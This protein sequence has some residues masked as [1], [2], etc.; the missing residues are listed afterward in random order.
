MK[1]PMK[2]NL[3][4]IQRMERLLNVASDETRLKI[5]FSLIDE[6]KCSCGIEHCCCG[7]C[8]KRGCMIEKCV[9]EIVE[10][11]KESQSLVS[12]QLKVLKDADLVSTRKEGVKVY[13]S[14]SDGHV[15]ELLKVIFEHINE[16]DE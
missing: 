16:E 2:P 13:Y 15:K 1:E 5:M 12:H 14:L 4:Q 10:E 8:Q 11:V 3:E 6:T 9:S 7:H